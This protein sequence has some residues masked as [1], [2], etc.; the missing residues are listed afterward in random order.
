MGLLVY[1]FNLFQIESHIFKK[2][3]KIKPHVTVAMEHTL[4]ILN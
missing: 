3:R 4:Y 1:D 2:K